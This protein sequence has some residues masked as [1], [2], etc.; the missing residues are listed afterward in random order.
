MKKYSACKRKIQKYSAHARKMQYMREKCSTCE[1]NA[2]VVRVMRY[3]GTFMEMK[4]LAVAMQLLLS[5]SSKRRKHFGRGFFGK[6]PEIP[7]KKKVT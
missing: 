7:A 2:A 5:P 3:T 1:K 6:I 4:P